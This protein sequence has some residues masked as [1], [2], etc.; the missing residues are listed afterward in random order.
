MR[1]A[2]ALLLVIW[3]AIGSAGVVAAGGGT[4]TPTPAASQ[5]PGVTPSPGLLN[6]RIE[7]TDVVWDVVPAAATYRLSGAIMAAPVN[8]VDP[9][10]PATSQSAR[11][12]NVDETF[13]G[14]VN[15]YTIPLPALGADERWVITPSPLDLVALDAAGQ[16]IAGTRITGV[17]EGGLEPCPSP[18]ARSTP[19]P[20]LPSTGEGG[21]ATAG[22]AAGY[23]LAAVLAVTVAALA[24]T[25]LVRMRRPARP[26]EGDDRRRHPYTST[27]MR[28]ALEERSRSMRRRS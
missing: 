7:G 9:C 6:L 10:I 3:A 24:F 8:T 19:A 4:A 5:T 28:P 26:L 15:R 23:T 11:T 1:E 22:G 16:Q 21:P 17:Y 27:G 12:L 2:L 13:P 20:Q 14:A 25:A 18:P